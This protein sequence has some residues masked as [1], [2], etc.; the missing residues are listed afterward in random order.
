VPAGHQTVEPTVLRAG[1]YRLDPEHS[2][3]LWKVDHLGFSTF[4]GRFDRFDAT[5]DFDPETPE[6]AALEVVVETASVST[7]TAGFADE[8]RGRSW[9]DTGRFPRRAS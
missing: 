9:L 5:L 3:I 7:H 4:V 6:E 2:I 8:L 1:A